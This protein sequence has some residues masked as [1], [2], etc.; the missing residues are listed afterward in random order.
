MSSENKHLTQVQSS[1]A[2]FGLA[3][4]LLLSVLFFLEGAEPVA[5]RYAEAA[6]RL[7]PVR[8]LPVPLLSRL[9]PV[10]SCRPVKPGAPGAYCS[11]NGLCR[12]RCNIPRVYAC[13][14][15]CVHLVCWCYPSCELSQVCLSSGHKVTVPFEIVVHPPTSRLPDSGLVKYRRERPE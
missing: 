4:A 14:R 12:G 13:L 3:L 10:G 1:T 7:L 2:F 8:L 15:C 6:A 5:C 9:G 11:S